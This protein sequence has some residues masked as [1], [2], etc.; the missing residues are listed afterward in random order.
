MSHASRLAAMQRTKKNIEEL[1]H[2]LNTQVSEFILQCPN[3]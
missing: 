2:A 1:I 3:R